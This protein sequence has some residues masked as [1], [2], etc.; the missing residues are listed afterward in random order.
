MDK[1]QSKA[2]CFLCGATTFSWGFIT[3]YGNQ[4]TFFKPSEQNFVE[5]VFMVGGDKTRARRCD[6]CGNVLLFDAS[7]VE[8]SQNPQ[9]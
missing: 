3:S 5:T 7:F 6:N 2:P 9:G 8:E 1:S 4:P